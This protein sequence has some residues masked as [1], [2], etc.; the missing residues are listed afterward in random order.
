MENH[1]LNILRD[2]SGEKFKNTLPKI[3]VSLYAASIIIE[4]IISILLYSQNLI[5]EEIHEYIR[6]YVF[7]PIVKSTL[8]LVIGEI[9]NRLVKDRWKQA[10]HIITITFILINVIYVHNIFQIAEVALCIPIFMTVALQ[11]KRLSYIVT[12]I[13]EAA[14]I[15]ITIYCTV[16]QKVVSRSTYY[17][18]SAVIA[19]IILFICNLT[20]CMSI[21]II[22]RKNQ[23]ISEALVEAKEA[24]K[25]ADAANESKSRFL[26]N[27]SHEIR[28]PINA[29]LGFD[30]M[31]LR[32]STEPQITDYAADIRTA[33]KTLL[34][35]IND[36]LDF[37]KI[38]S[39]KME[40][41]PVEYQVSSVI[42]DL[43]NII[44][45]K[46]YDK[47]LSFNVEVDPDIPFC[48]VGDEVRIKQVMLNILSNAVKYTDSGLVTMRIKYRTCDDDN[49]FFRAEVQDTGRGMKQEDM[50]KL[51]QPFERIDEKTNRSIEGTGLGMS[52][53]K[54]LLSLMESELHV[55]S[56]YG[57]GSTFSFEIK[58]KVV[59]WKPMGDYE[60]NY[61]KS[62]QIEKK[63]HESFI[64]PDAR[65]LVVDDLPLNLKVV[66]SLLKNT[67][68]K[69]DTA[70][71]GQECLEYAGNFKYNVIFIDHMMPDMDGMET[72]ARL[73]KDKN[74]FN[75]DTPTVALTANAISGAR[76]Q[77]IDAGF[78]EYL[79]K[80][81][82]SS[83][84][85]KMLISLLPEEMVTICSEEVDNTDNI[86]D[87]AEVDY[88][89]VAAGVEASGGRDVYDMA[90]EEFAITLDSRAGEI[91]KFWN[92]GDIRNYTIQV[93]A[94]KSAARLIGAME[95]SELAKELEQCGKEEDI[96]TI[97]ARTPELLDMYRSLKPSLE[98][99]TGKDE[100][101][102]DNLKEMISKQQIDEAVE[103]MLE[104]LE[105]FDFDMVESV[106]N[107]LSEYNMPEEFEEKYKKLKVLFAEVARDE[108]IELLRG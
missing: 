6:L 21:D 82:D 108:M 86:Q 89:D 22:R 34:G 102:K 97:N 58:Q 104:G 14:V 47:G 29:V 96:E 92:D 28:T 50:K 54:Q 79:T 88:I 9:I 48:L 49:I 41:I 18:P 71:S 62:K 19:V 70:V 37:S 10:V 60:E 98:I 52:I 40:L 61:K 43:V 17:L 26:S 103:V 64:A 78:T 95:L 20:A 15:Y 94:L 38:E 65:I 90:V 107:Q 3:T 51:F 80:P 66:C 83:K 55:E 93:H 46:V 76:K 32:E 27:M 39:G 81:I 5:Y 73:K 75:Y 23:L 99:L 57:E 69:I 35:L 85:E 1:I 105:V 74:G 11:N 30:E 53:T 84:L 33:G 72:L 100:G 12:F 45:S 4:I 13:S 63:Y 106:I 87:Y 44:S 59:D 56:V 68:I 31:I 16:A 2:N 67:R 36:I 91:E 7:N 24:Q 8:I 77:Y 42:N 25:R 101:A